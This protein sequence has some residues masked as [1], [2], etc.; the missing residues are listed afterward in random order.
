MIARAARSLCCTPQTVRNYLERYPALAQVMAEERELIVDT[1]ELK[2]HS[3]VRRG[4]PWAVCFT[5]KCLGKDRGYAERQERA[6]PGGQPVPSGDQG[7]VFVLGGTTEQYIAKLREVRARVRDAGQ[8]VPFDGTPVSM[9]EDRHGK[10]GT[11]SS[12]QCAAEVGVAGEV[13]D[14]LKTT[15][16]PERRK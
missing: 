9:R 7:T 10:N 12:I 14:Y 13:V 11:A 8:S 5:L 3:A 6:G 1:A 4:E 16:Q 2:L 15:G